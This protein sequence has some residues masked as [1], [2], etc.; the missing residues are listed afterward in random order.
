MWVWKEEWEM[1]AGVSDDADR[2]VLADSLAFAPPDAS[3]VSIS[4]DRSGC[5][6]LV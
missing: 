5:P 2:Y 6:N 4:L 1:V 3:L